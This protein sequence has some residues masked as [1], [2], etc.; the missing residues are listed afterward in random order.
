MK[1]KLLM[2]LGTLLFILPMNGSIT[3]HHK[4][5]RSKICKIIDESK[6]V[7]RA[8]ID[9]TVEVAD[10]E[11]SLQ[12]IFLFPLH[13]ADITVTDKNGN[14]VIEENQTNLYEGKV[15]YVHNP[16][17]YPYTLVLTSPAVDITGEITL[18]E[19]N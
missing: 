19:E 1:A 5:R 12:I 11:T 8:P 17:A 7:T 15:L 9:Y 2:I 4:K 16:K 14:V 3:T 6:A 18:E 10:D 13:E